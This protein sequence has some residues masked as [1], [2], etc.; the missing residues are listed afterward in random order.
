M[1]TDPNAALRRQIEKSSRG[2]GRANPLVTKLSAPV[3][4]SDEDREAADSICRDIREVQARRDII[5]DGDRPQFVHVI[6][7]G[8]AAR[9]KVVPDGSRQITAILV[10]G[11]F[12]DLHITILGEMDHG[13]TALT[14]VKVA[15]VPHLVMENL[16]VDRPQLGRA[17]WWATLVDEATLRAWIVNL[18]RR[19]A[20]ERVAHLFCELHARLK[21]VGLADEDDFS[22]PLTQEILADALGLTPVHINRVLQRLRSQDLIELEGGELRILNLPHLRKLAGFDPTYLHRGRL[23]RIKDRLS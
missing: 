9:Y 10:P 8:W 22:L 13:I 2:G 7:E 6:M 5:S 17:L 4:L 21:L 15:L 18:G 16:P 12:C 23:G 11:D 3:D 14:R 1:A 19:D 20:A